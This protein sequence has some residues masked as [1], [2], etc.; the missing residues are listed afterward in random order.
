MNT[1][2]RAWAA[3]MAAI[4]EARGLHESGANP[5]EFAELLRHAR[6]LLDIL[7]EEAA[8]QSIA[9]PADAHAVL[10]QLRSR[11]AVLEKDVAA[12]WH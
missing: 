5:T 8:A 1:I 7:E 4:D 10:D 3:F 11:L 6:E 2:E 12:S 9:I